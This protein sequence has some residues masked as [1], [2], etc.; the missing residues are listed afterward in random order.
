MMGDELASVVDSMAGGLMGVVGDADALVNAFDSDFTDMNPV[1]ALDAWANRAG[2]SN[3]LTSAKNAYLANNLRALLNVDPSSKMDMTEIYHGEIEFPNGHVAKFICP[4]ETATPASEEFLLWMLQFW[5]FP[6]PKLIMSITGGARDFLNPNPFRNDPPDAKYK[7]MMNHKDDDEAIAKGIA[8]FDKLGSKEKAAKLAERK[9]K[10]KSRIEQLFSRGIARA[11]VDSQAWILSGGSS[12]GV[13]R[14]AGNAAADTRGTQS[15]MTL[16]GQ[17]A[18]GIMTLKMVKDFAKFLVKGERVK[19]EKGNVPMTVMP[20]S[21]HTHFIMVNTQ[22]A[23]FGLEVMFR[24][25]LEDALCSMIPG[26]LVVVN[27]GPNTRETVLWAVRKNRAVIVIKGSGR[28]ADELA[29]KYKQHQDKKQEMRRAW[30]AHKQSIE[31]Q[32]QRAKANPGDVAGHPSTQSS[33]ELMAHVRTELESQRKAQDEARMKRS[34][35]TTLLHGEPE[36]GEASPEVARRLPDRAGSGSSA[37][38]TNS[39]LMQ[40]ARRESNATAVSKRP[41]PNVHFPSE[42]TPANQ[43]VAKGSATPR[44]DDGP[45]KGGNASAEKQKKEEEDKKAKKDK[46]KKKKKKSTA[47]GEDE[48]E[49]SEDKDDLP[50]ALLND[51]VEDCDAA[52]SEIIASPTVAIFDLL[53]DPLERMNELVILSLTRNLSPKNKQSEIDVAMLKHGWKLFAMYDVNAKHQKRLSNVLIYLI[54]IIN[55]AATLLTV[56]QQEIRTAV[57]FNDSPDTVTWFRRVVTVLPICVGILIAISNKFNANTKWLFLRNSAQC[58]KRE[59]FRYRTRTGEYNGDTNSEHRSTVLARALDEIA[60]KLAQ[61]EVGDLALRKSAEFFFDDGYDSTDIKLAGHKDSGDQFGLSLLNAEDYYNRRLIVE[62]NY[63]LRKTPL[64]QRNSRVL[65]ITVYIL[66]SGS[67][68]LGIYSYEIWIAA[69]MA[70]VAGL[71]M[72]LEYQQYQR[73]LTKYSR[74]VTELQR[75]RQWWQSLQLVEKASPLNISQLVEGTEAILDEEVNSWLAQMK[76]AT[77]RLKKSLADNGGDEGKSDGDKKTLTVSNFTPGHVAK[78]AKQKTG[79]AL[80]SLFPA[81]RKK[82]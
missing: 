52:M 10:I 59:L 46:K 32:R 70:I 40:A 68:L 62:I 20:D 17:P 74:T 58:V 48:G 81:K 25:Q 35:W 18:V 56:I 77:D 37:K 21:N 42:A 14:M 43:G 50:P 31:E 75:M 69:S 4:H 66:S 82:E 78:A 24:T 3:P 57:T 23:A 79:A 72:V 65:L 15:S 33:T 36:Q 47:N 22:K 71:T 54:I 34:T 1:D 5:D 44:G 27:G 67:A 49:L 30:E 80:H 26:V 53:N 76:T 12:T 29:D 73:R 2:M 63:Y 13:M 16:D 9:A 8:G 11:V 6:L 61:S 45:P 39:P 38:L 64:L 60:S 41:A 51:F 28:F 55:I 19:L 7:E